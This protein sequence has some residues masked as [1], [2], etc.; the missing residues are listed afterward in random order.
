MIDTGVLG[1]KSYSNSGSEQKLLAG[2]MKKSLSP[3]KEENSR[4]LPQ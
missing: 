3:L 1:T 4:K 2:A